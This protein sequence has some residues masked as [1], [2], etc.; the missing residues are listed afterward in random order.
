MFRIKELRLKRKLSMRQVAKDLDIP[1]T[2]YISYEKE[3]HEPNS[4]ILIRIADYFNC[5][6]DYLIGRSDQEVDDSVLDKVAMIDQ[7]ILETS[8]NIY[9]A[10]K[11]QKNRDSK[12]GIEEL[13]GETVTHQEI[14][15]IVKYR[16][17]D[18]YGKK[19]VTD[20]LDTEYERCS[21]EIDVTDLTIELPM[22]ELPASAGIGTWLEDGYNTPVT[23]RKTKEA[24]RANVVI[25]V[26]GDS[27]E[28]LYTD[29]DRVLVKI[30][31]DVE[32]GE[33]GIF[34]VDGEGF[35]KKKGERELI[36]VN[37]EYDNIPVG[38]FTEYR[39]F[40]KVLGKAEI[41]E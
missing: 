20:L 38:E 17:L 23:V 14:E 12:K 15:H 13:F 1:Y 2:T 35:I 3:T 7:D 8:G 32:L 22:P 26:S 5:S 10:Q 21:S 40:G 37:P 33:I 11:I 31:P 34:I 24:E 41:L 4:E 6:I 36:S 16:S 28:P 29:G 27:M 30:Q 25:K 39:C 9:Q 19:A 18:E